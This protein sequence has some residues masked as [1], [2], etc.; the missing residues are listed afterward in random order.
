[1]GRHAAADEPAADAARARRRTGPPGSVDRPPAVST[2]STAS[3]AGPRVIDASAASTA[4]VSS[5]R[6]SK[7]SDRRAQRL[8]LVPDAA[9]EPLAVGG[10]ERLLDQHADPHRHERR[11]P[12]QRP[13]PAR[14]IATPRS[15]IAAGTTCG[16]TLTD[17]TSW[18]AATTDP[19]SAV[20]TSSGSIRSSSST[21]R[22]ADVEHARRARPGG[23]PGSRWGRAASRP[24][25]AHRGGEPE[26]RLVL[27]EVAGLH[28][29]HGDGSPRARPGRRR[30]APRGR[31][32][33]AAGPSTSA[34]P[35]DAQVAREDGAGQV[36]AGRV[37][38]GTIRSSR[39]L[40]SAP[41]GA[42][43]PTRAS[44]AWIA[45]RV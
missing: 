32:R 10:P 13:R 45:R 29:Q 33:R 43:Q 12:D 16:A 6:Y 19:S 11:D 18:P 36:R 1:M 27:V 44:A 35:R 4:A 9:L 23:R 3:A 25:A 41:S 14:A 24:G 22:D 30:R 34:S 38:P 20:N 42:A 5:G 26:R 8:H 2:T 7:R 40:R 37:R 31:P 39:T 21:S 17:A 28:D 15:T